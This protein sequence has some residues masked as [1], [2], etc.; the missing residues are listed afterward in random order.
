M[1]SAKFAMFLFQSTNRNLTEIDASM[2][3]D[4]IFESI[5]QWCVDTILG[6]AQQ[7]IDFIVDKLHQLCAKIK[8]I[9][10]KLPQQS[11]YRCTNENAVIKE[12]TD[13]AIKQGSKAAC[14]AFNNSIRGKLPE[15]KERALRMKVN[16]I[17]SQ[18]AGAA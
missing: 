9:F 8:T 15:E 18:I 10:A 14:E 4:D 1:F 2:F 13:A 6:I 5:I 3:I 17:P 11:K 7:I 16:E 12:A